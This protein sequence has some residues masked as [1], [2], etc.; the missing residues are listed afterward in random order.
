MV[1]YKDTIIIFPLFNP[2]SHKASADALGMF[3][4]FVLVLFSESGTCFGVHTNYYLLSPKPSKKPRK[5]SI[6]F[7]NKY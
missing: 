1:D 5:I 7:L 6:Q 4:F 2:P 3:N